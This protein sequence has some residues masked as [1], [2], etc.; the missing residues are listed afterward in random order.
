MIDDIF[1]KFEQS[2]FELI[3]KAAARMLMLKV[4]PMLVLARILVNVI[5]LNCFFFQLFYIF[6]N[7]QSSQKYKILLAV[8]MSL[9][10]FLKFVMEE[11]T[12]II[13]VS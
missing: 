1:G 3:E 13:W 5:T 9:L 7:R 6:S 12:K 11:L 2:L 4:L 10:Q 8:Q